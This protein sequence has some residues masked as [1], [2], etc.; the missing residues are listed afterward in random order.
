MIDIQSIR[1][2]FLGSRPNFAL[3]T[4]AALLGISLEAL[5]KEIADGVILAV[6]TGVGLRVPR[7][8]L[9][10]AAL[11]SWP[12]ADIERALG[13]DAPRLLPA[14]L[15]L[16]P[17][18]ARIPRYQRDMLRHLAHA[19]DT[20]IDEVLARELEDVA[21]AHAAELAPIPGFEAAMAWPSGA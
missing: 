11:R 8:E 7:E 5:K 4:A 21:C 16:V 10:A 1:R 14:T 13:D 20:T 2:I 3:L 9:I 17:L 19:G 12:Q 6:P 15:R 18:R